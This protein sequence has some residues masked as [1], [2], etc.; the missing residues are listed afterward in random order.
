MI[1]VSLF[2]FD[3]WFLSGGFVGVDIFFVI[4]GFLMTG[5][6]FKGFEKNTFNI[7]GFIKA[8]GKRIVPPLLIVCLF[9]LI[10]S[11]FFLYDPELYNSLN[12]IS[13]AM[14]F[15]SNIFFW[16]TT[17][18]F[19]PG[20]ETNILLH[21]WSLSVEWQFYI[22]YPLVLV[23]IKKFFNLKVTKISIFIACFFSFLL[24]IYATPLW[25]T[26]SY[27][28]LPTRGWEMLLGGV[29]FLVNFN[30]NNKLRK[31]TQL[32]GFLF[33]FISCVFFTKETLWPSYFAIVPTLGAFLI[34]V[35]N[36]DSILL[37][38][39]I[40][41]AI[42]LWSYSIY[43][44][45]WIVVYLINRYLDIENPIT[46]IAGLLISIFLGYLSFKF[47]EKGGFNNPIKTISFMVIASCS[48]LLLNK[49]LISNRS[50]SDT[51]END[52]VT[53]YENYKDNTPW[54]DNTCSN[55]FCENG[56]LF[57]WGDSHARALYSGLKESLSNITEVTTTSCSPSLK[58]PDYVLK[59]RIQC[60]INNKEALRQIIL[61]KPSV[62]ILA[63]KNRHDENDW[64]SITNEL[65][66]YGVEHVVV[67][68]PVPQ[69]KGDLPLLVAKKY[70]D[71]DLINKKDMDY[72]IFGSDNLMLKE[73]RKI[74]TYISILNTLC[75]NDKCK[76]KVNNND[77]HSLI[78]SDY[79]HLNNEGSKFIADIIL[80]KISTLVI[81]D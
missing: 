34:L 17:S 27:F 73:D 1:T 70:L 41:Q 67:I 10:F 39:K 53:Y 64:I 5:I 60:N 72:R 35:S 25:A 49:E 68:G 40:M 12:Q 48:I 18:Y 6:I 21:T 2:H 52:L 14:F 16:K 3:V 44:W 55:D 4:S 77:L 23:T 43:L 13:T 29:A 80:N 26:S 76:F 42:G 9:S 50:I 28:L 74:Y 36:C 81:K 15:V 62:V 33:I 24:S 30:V 75:A 61:K 56:G 37:K 11:Y 19:A 79:G 66:I 51:P 8:R 22:I 65:K 78:A 58:Y 32:V 46:I 31:L 54:I 38:N 63:Q 57:L 45:H 47:I 7:G 59:S 20:S 69:F 71:S